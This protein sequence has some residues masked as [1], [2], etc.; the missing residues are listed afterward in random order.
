[1]SLV[2][3]V[4]AAFGVLCEV[5]YSR[6]CMKSLDISAASAS[7]PFGILLSYNEQ[8]TARWREW[9]SKQTEA[10]LQ[11]PAGDP[12]KEMGTIRDLLFHILIVEWVYAKVLSGENWENEWQKFD[13]TTVTGIFAVAAEAQP[14]LRAFPDSATDAQLAKRTPSPLAADSLSPG[15]GANF[16]PTLSCIALGIG[17]RLR[18]FCE[19]R[20]M[21]QTGSTTSSLA[22]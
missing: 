10:V 22:M 7:V 2:C 13:R 15:A 21:R 6:D 12:S 14:K 19:K 20:C 11:I 18:C 8:E 16:S 4:V 5:N 17:H 3:S 1:M 9:F